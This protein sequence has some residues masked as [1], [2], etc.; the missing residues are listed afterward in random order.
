MNSKPGML[1]TPCKPPPIVNVLALLFT[2][3]RKYVRRLRAIPYPRHLG[4]ADVF[5]GVG[6]EAAEG[7]SPDAVCLEDHG[8]ARGNFVVRA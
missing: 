4:I 3:M 1:L 6:P 8:P 7:D 5:H 2:S